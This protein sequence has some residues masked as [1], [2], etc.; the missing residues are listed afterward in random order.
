[1][2]PASDDDGFDIDS[3]IDLAPWAVAGRYPED[4]ENPT[5]TEA[6]RLVGLAHDAVEQAHR[7]IAGR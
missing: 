3:L 5:G 4:I 6:R 2:L 7:S 1:L